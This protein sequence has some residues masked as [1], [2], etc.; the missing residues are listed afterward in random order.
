MTIVRTS[1]RAV[2]LVGLMFM[3]IVAHSDIKRL[4][5]TGRGF[6]DVVIA[7]GQRHIFISGQVAFDGTG[8]V[9]KGDIA[10]QTEQVMKNI[11]L[12]LKAS[13]ASVDDLVK[14]TIFV[15]DYTPEKRDLIQSVRDRHISADSGPAS[16]LIGVSRLVSDEFLIEIEAQAITSE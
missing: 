5:P 6:S 16:T 3:P 1:A 9:G 11:T 4:Y 12:W 7:S 10:A 15:V 13:G 2:V 14:I 8:V